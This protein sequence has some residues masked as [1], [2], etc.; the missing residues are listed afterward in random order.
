MLA[1]RGFVTRSKRDKTSGFV[2]EQARLVGK[3]PKGR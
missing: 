1:I 2:A 3:G